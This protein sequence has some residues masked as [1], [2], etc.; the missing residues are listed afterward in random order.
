LRELGTFPPPPPKKKPLFLLLGNYWRWFKPYL[1]FIFLHSYLLLIDEVFKTPPSLHLILLKHKALKSDI[2][3]F[4]S[5]LCWMQMSDLQSCT[6][7]VSFDLHLS[8]CT[9]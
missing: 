5:K 4:I 3:E 1:T 8:D 7:H 2:D 6:S 9:S